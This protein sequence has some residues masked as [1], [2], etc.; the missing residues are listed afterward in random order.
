[1]GCKKPWNRE[2]L[3]LTMTKAF[4]NGPLKAHHSEILFERE[5]CLLPEAQIE[6]DRQLRVQE[7]Y[8]LLRDKSTYPPE[9]ARELTRLQLGKESAPKPKQTRKCPTSDCRG[10][11]SDWN[12]S[13]CKVTF[14]KDCGETRD[15]GHV[16]DP[17][18]VETFSLLKKDTKG[19]PGCGEMIF[20]ISGCSQ[21]WCPSCHTAFDWNTLQVETGRIHNPH[22]YDYAR[23]T[24]T[25]VREPGDVP[26]GGRMSLQEILTR[27][28]TDPFF[29]D[30]HRQATHCEML[31]R[32]TYRLVPINT[33][34]L[35]IN[36]LRGTLTPEKFKRLLEQ[37]DKNYKKTVEIRAVIQ[38]FIDTVDGILRDGEDPKHMLTTLKDYFNDTMRVIAKRYG[39]KAPSIF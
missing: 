9:L 12:C 26:C 32:I 33:L 36:Y 11:L 3:D 4:V 34:P 24:G 25:L 1:M 39:S 5:K 21:M 15:S 20:K 35:R 38:M 14:C 27:F 2:F 23:R 7:I 10:F 16:C 6:L 29:L 18:T 30:F 19:C 17:G 28:G 8:R 31:L 13:L 37:G 22:Y